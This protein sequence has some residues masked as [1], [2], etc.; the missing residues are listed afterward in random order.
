MPLNPTPYVTDKKIHTHYLANYERLFGPWS[1]KP[2]CLLELG[3]KD[4]GSLQMWRDYFPDGT[5]AGL[6][7]DAVSIDDPTG[8][9]RVYQGEQ[10]DR[11]LLDR[12]ADEC[13]PGG[14]DL[15]IDDASHVGAPSR[16]SF[17][18]LFEHH[19][20][21]G[22]VYVLEDWGAGYWPSCPDGAYLRPRDSSRYARMLRAI[23]DALDRKSLTRN[24][25][26]VARRLRR[27]L[28]PKR[29]RSHDYGMVGLLKE[30]VDEVG[31]G[32]A[33]APGYGI[34]PSRPSLISSLEILHGQAFVHKATD[35]S[36]K[37]TGMPSAT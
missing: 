7:I 4:G 28:T 6:D 20:V 32:D 2:V 10:Q 18:H 16:V 8:R 15:I 17:W 35:K 37:P 14:F 9:I 31:M 25:R 19:L 3:V 30:I 24:Q 11:D 26:R 36:L 27:E 21:D 12:I 33:T 5:I 22:G 34:V 13:A 29:I 23:D 1:D